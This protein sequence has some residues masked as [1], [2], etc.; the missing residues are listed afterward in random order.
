M[1]SVAGPTDKIESFGA[2]LSRDVG[3]RARVVIA[4]GSAAT[5]YT[6]GGY[7]S[8]DIDVVGPRP[9]IEAVLKRWGFVP[10]A[11]T[12]GRVYWSRDDL[13]LFVDILHRTGGPGRGGRPL[14][15]RTRYGPVR[16]SAVE[17]V[18]VRRLVFWS[19]DGHPELLVQAVDLY[20]SRRDRLDLEYLLAEVRYERVEQAFDEMRRLADSPRRRRD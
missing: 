8:G 1:A 7:I 6:G 2:L 11:D 4:G 14:V 16:I 5:V 3:A 12:D 19:R 15:L 17:D 13:G 18:I 9:L 20:K 10:E